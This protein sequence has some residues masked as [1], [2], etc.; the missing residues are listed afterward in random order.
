M[1]TS[2]PPSLAVD[3]DP[4]TTALGRQETERGRGRQVEDESPPLGVPLA[5]PPA[6]PPGGPWL[7]IRRIRAHVLGLA[8]FSSLRPFVSHSIKA[9]MCEIRYT[10]LNRTEAGVGTGVHVSRTKNWG[11]DQKTESLDL[12]VQ[13]I[14]GACCQLVTCQCNLV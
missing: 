11:S 12:E 6:R 2:L 3:I 8:A 5:R 14:H 7:R 1:L 9:E 10:E 13:N 4:G